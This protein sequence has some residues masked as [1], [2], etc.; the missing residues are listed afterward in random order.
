MMT[1]NRRDWR[2]VA[3]GF[4]VFVMAPILLYWLLS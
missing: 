2:G 4:S 1:A 3:L